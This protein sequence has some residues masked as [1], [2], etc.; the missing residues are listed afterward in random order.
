MKKMKITSPADISVSIVASPSRLLLLL[1]NQPVRILRVYIPDHSVP[2]RNGSLQ[3]FGRQR[4]EHL[5][6][7]NP[8]Q[9]PCAEGRIIPFAR[10]QFLG[11]RSQIE[12]DF[13]LLQVFSD[14]LKLDVDDPLDLVARQAVKNDNLVDT[15]QKLRPEARAQRLIHPCLHLLEL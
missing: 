10:E 7:D 2:L 5:F 14:A 9:G 13:L 4:I 1:K 15:V 11:L 3:D 8:L 6:L 12:I